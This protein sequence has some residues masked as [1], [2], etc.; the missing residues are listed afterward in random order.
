[1]Q[2]AHALA[3]TSVHD[4]T[5]TVVVEALA[6]GLPV[7]C[8]NHCGFKDAVDFSSGIL[9]AA[10]SPGVLISGLAQAIE[11]LQDEDFRFELARG[12]LVQSRKNEWDAKARAANDIYNAKS[13]A[14]STRWGSWTVGGGCE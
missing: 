5:S 1:M 14:V 8:P 3:V 4:L 7:V 12:A 2:S 6:N 10:S 9:V 11:H 13:R